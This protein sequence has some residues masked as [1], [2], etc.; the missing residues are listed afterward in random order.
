MKRLCRMKKMNCAEGVSIWTA[1][2]SSMRSVVS[3]NSC[4]TGAAP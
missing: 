1:T 2:P 4:G 3:Y